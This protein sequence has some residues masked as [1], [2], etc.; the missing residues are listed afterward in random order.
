M[1][2]YSGLYTTAG[3][4]TKNLIYT[5]KIQYVSISQELICSINLDLQTSDA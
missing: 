5:Y 1:A 4:N 3:Q 2:L